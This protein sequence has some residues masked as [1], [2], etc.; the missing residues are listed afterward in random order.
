MLKRPSMNSPAS[1]P[2]IDIAP[3]LAGDADGERNVAREVG[4]ACRDIG[5]FYITGHGI[6]ARTVA[7]VFGMSGT[8]FTSPD[9][10]KSAAAFIGAGGNR[11]YIQLG[12]EKLDPGK[13][14][15]IKEAFNIGLELAADDPDLLAGKPFRARNLWPALPEFRTTM[16]DYFD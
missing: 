11:G 7:D 4:R 14:A 15:D 1:I 8:F 10:L 9:S 16:L 12:G 6:P 3:L 5:F 13:P 2:I